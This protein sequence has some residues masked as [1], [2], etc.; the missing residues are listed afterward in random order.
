VPSGQSDSSY[1]VT[2]CV[3]EQALEGRLGLRIDQAVECVYTTA[4][5]LCRESNDQNL[6]MGLGEVT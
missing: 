4:S 5:S 3:L 1:L 6:W 2:S